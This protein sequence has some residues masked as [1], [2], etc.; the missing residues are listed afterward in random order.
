MKAGN[1][2]YRNI[3]ISRGIALSLLMMLAGA[4]S[5]CSEDDKIV[6]EVITPP[7][8]IRLNVSSDLGALP[9]EVRSWH[10]TLF[11]ADDGQCHSVGEFPNAASMVCAPDSRD[12][13]VVAYENGTNLSFSALSSGLPTA[14]YYVTV[15]DVNN[16]M[17]Q[18][19]YGRSADPA[20]VKA[21][22]MMHPVTARIAV[23]VVNTP[24]SLKSLSMKIPGIADRL[25]IFSGEIEASKST[26]N[27]L[28]IPALETKGPVTVMPMANTNKWNL[29]CRYTFEDGQE[30]P[31]T[32]P[33]SAAIKSGQSI[34]IIVDFSTYETKGTCRVI[35]RNCD[36]GA[37]K[38]TNY[39]ADNVLKEAPR[40]SNRY[41]TVSVM[42][43]DG[44][45]KEVDVHYAMCS[46]APSH[47]ASIWNDWNNSKQMRD[48]MSFVNFTHDFDSPVKIRIKKKHGFGSVRVR[49]STYNITP[50]NLGD[51]TVEITL[52]EW[53]KRKVSVEFDGNRYTN[54][55]ILPNRPDPDRPDPNNLPPGMIYYGPGIHNPEQINLKEGETLYIDEGAEVFGKVNVS[56]SNVT[57]TGRGILSGARLPHTGGTYAHGAQLIETN[58]N[59]LSN[60][61]YFTIS[62]ISIVDS[63]NWTLS[64]YNTDHVTIDNINLMCWILNGDGIDLCSVTDAT[65]KD[66]FIRTYDD[67]ITLKVNSLSLTATK[68]IRISHN[69]IWADFARGIIVGPECGLNTRAGISDCT[70]EDCIIL[71]YPTKPSSLNS[72]GAAL[73][74]SQYPQGG[75]TSGNIENITF[76]NIIVDNIANGGRPIA[77]WQKSGQDNAKINKLTFSDIRIIDESGKCTSSGIFCNNNSIS[78]MIFERVTYNGVPIG[79]SG[80]LT[81]DKPENVDISYQ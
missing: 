62:G 17:P 14:S 23:T 81:I 7:D 3:A 79:Q 77:V 73:S 71:E 30:I 53:D 54:L 10:H 66:C 35:Y 1:T 55:M 33:V 2:S 39:S 32:L 80:K 69:L 58:A 60:R 22:V 46:D 76:R 9:E 41:Y 47:H 5:S 44:S 31:G 26:G 15:G 45:W 18:I 51:N 29:E 70:I 25:R 78:N 20:N 57:I 63:P 59:R 74:V 52:P 19:W 8:D 50:E 67:C 75:P 27:D 21:T 6:E 36:H 13:A 72:D 28:V 12:I 48:T 56:G 24:A 34:E 64:V 68:D 16:P 61:G 65:I 40:E 37:T 11:T 43:K 4:V 42:Q 38:W 49:P